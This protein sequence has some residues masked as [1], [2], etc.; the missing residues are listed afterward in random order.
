MRCSLSTLAAALVIFTAYL[1]AVVNG[2]TGMQ[3]LIDAALGLVLVSHRL[4]NVRWVTFATFFSKFLV[5]P[6]IQSG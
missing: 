2:A 5:H 1:H 6:A 3:V 4:W